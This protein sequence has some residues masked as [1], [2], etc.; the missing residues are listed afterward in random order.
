VREILFGCFLLFGLLTRISTLPL[1]AVI[2]VA[3]WTT[4][5]PMLAKGQFWGMAHEARTDYSMLLCLIF[6]SIVGAGPLSVDAVL[7]CCETPQTL[8]QG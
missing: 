5:L 7:S 4:K 1:L 8:R 2:P 3:L 6:L